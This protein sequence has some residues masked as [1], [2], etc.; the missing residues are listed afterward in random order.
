MISLICGILKKWFKWTYPQNRNRVTDI[1]NIVMATKKDT[2]GG[3]GG[4]KL[5]VWD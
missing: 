1:E 4:D 3:A 2:Q 5:G